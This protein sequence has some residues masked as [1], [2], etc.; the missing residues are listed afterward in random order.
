MRASTFGTSERKPPRRT[1]VR[2]AAALAAA[3]AAMM[4]P[5]IAGQMPLMDWNQFNAPAG[6]SSSLQPCPATPPTGTSGGG[7]GQK[8]RAHGLYQFIKYG[9]SQPQPIASTWQAA[10]DCVAG[11]P[12]PPAPAISEQESEAAEADIP[13]PPA[14]PAPNGNALEENLL[15]VASN[16][17]EVPPAEG[18][19]DAT[20]QRANAVPEPA[21]SG[22]MGLGLLAL[23]GARRRRAAK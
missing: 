13:P 12:P 22:L 3:A 14:P 20:P 1:A 5:A 21:S 19:G 8:G 17:A 16:Q 15:V 2:Y 7:S 18:T 23:W 6:S 10:A 11:T 9:A 4:Q